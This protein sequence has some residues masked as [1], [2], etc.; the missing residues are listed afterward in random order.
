MS[1]MKTALERATEKAE[2]L[3]RASEEELRKWKCIPAGESLA[4]RYLKGEA[5]LIAELSRH[6]DS[7]KKICN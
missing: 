2:A 1:G 4:A 6:D 7:A 3:G 5:N